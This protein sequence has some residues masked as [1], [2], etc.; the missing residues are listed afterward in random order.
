MQIV[1]LK[2]NA[3]CSN[4]E[5]KKRDREGQDTNTI[6]YQASDLGGLPIGAQARWGPLGD[7]G[8]YTTELSQPRGGKAWVFI[9]KFID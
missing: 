2:V 9:H 8:E 7:S 6:C 1:Y 4:R 5:I 3:R